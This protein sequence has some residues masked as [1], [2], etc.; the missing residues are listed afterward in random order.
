MLAVVNKHCGT[1]TF[2]QG[3]VALGT[4]EVNTVASVIS[5]CFSPEIG[6]RVDAAFEAEGGEAAFAHH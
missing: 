5:R 2:A 4:D 1:D 3:D 6:L